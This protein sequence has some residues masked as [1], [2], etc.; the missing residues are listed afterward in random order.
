M[1]STSL[2]DC[3]L[4]LHSLTIINILE[5]NLD[6]TQNIYVQTTPTACGWSST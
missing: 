4:L 1:L 2:I 6:T 5:L 3:M